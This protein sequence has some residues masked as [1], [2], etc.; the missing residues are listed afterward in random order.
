MTCYD[1]QLIVTYV[2]AGAVLRVR[3]ALPIARRFLVYYSRVSF[4][5]SLCTLYVVD[6]DGTS[7]TVGNRVLCLMLNLKSAKI[8]KI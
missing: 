8:F 7:A 3:V 4:E 1:D 5:H 2:V 6:L